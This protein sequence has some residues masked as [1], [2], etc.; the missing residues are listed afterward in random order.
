MLW[1]FGKVIA[2]VFVFVWLRGTLP[3]LRYDQFMRLGW[4]VLLPINLVWI[5]LVAGYKVV[6][7][8]KEREHPLGDL[9]GDLGPDSAGGAGVAVEVHREAAHP[10]GAGG[11]PAGRQLPAPTAGPTGAGESRGPSAWS[12]SAN[13][14]TS[15]ASGQA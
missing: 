4:K 9:R 1:F 15:S 10:R 6:D 12:P 14:P 3:R 11:G 5:L 8:E 7:S 2:L 13:P